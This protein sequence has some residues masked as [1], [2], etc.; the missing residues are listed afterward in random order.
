VGNVELVLVVL[1]ILMLGLFIVALIA[2]CVFMGYQLYKFAKII[3]VFEDD[4]QDAIDA[5]EQ[6][7]AA[8]EGLLKKP[9]FFDSP[10]VKKEV[11]ESLE[12]VRYMQLQ[13]QGLANRLTE[14][15]KQKYMRIEEDNTS[16]KE[17]SET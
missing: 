11:E 6:T 3:M 9:M 12:A 17:E 4:L 10:E 2:L 15:S 13:I 16:D 7:G 14:R 1:A 5:T 8:L